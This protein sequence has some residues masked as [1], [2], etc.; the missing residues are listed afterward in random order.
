MSKD[1]ESAP[2]LNRR[3]GDDPV[4]RFDMAGQWRALTSCARWVAQLAETHREEATRSRLARP[5]HAPLPAQCEKWA[6]GTLRRNG[7]HANMTRQ[8]NLG[9]DRN[10]VE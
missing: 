3:L 1:D 4:A 2:R 8:M 6:S 7:L 5:P 9:I 10:G